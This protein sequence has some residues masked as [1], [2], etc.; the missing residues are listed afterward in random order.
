MN[1]AGLHLTRDVARVVLV[2]DDGT[3]MASARATGADLRE[4][5]RQALRQALGGGEAR[6]IGL[7]VDPLENLD[8]TAANHGLSDLGRVVVSRA[9][10]AVV[11]AEAWAGAARGERHAVCL[12][13]GET[14]FAGLLLDGR[15]W[16]GAHDLA[17]AA[18]W[19]ALNPVD[20]QDY[21]KHGSLAAEVSYT[22][23]AKRLAWRIHAG[24][25]SAVLERVPN[26]E[27]IT[28]TDVFEAAR[29]GD[30]V[31]IS[32]VRDAAR[33][34]GMA[35]ANLA[36]AV[37]PEVAVLGGGIASAGDL[38]LEPVRQECL[39]RLPPALASQVRCELSPL[40]EDAVAIGAAR[41]AG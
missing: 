11:A 4:A 41:L 17:G 12:F 27:A 10:E 37:D 5:A 32:V 36:V 2:D 24:D 3:V 15:P 7:A 34:I 35:I 13:V 9:G 21:R 28:A 18:A 33:F 8:I 22:G 39:R 1:A 40:G 31:S 16:A 25:R 30:G 14:V 29:A 19:L 6:T 26:P 38:V 20:R 23:I